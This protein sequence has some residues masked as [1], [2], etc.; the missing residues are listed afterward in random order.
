MKLVDSI[1]K[2]MPW[3]V[4]LDTIPKGIISLLIAGVALFLITV[5]WSTPS[6]T[7]KKMLEAIGNILEGCYKR[8]VFTRTHAQL[9][10]DAMFNSISDCMALVQMEIPKISNGHYSQQAANILAALEG[11]ERERNQKPWDFHKIDQFKLEALRGLK[12]F[13][14]EAKK[15]FPVPTSLTEELFFSQ[16]E[17]DKPPTIKTQKN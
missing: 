17:A 12:V 13:A 6:S 2:F 16:E 14:K 1:Q 10:H 3:M 7:E 8:A 9:S 11:I 5:I 4:E 15:P